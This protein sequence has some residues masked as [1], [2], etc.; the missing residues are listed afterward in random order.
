MSWLDSSGKLWLFGG[1]GYDSGWQ[2]CG[3]NDLWKYDPATREWTWVSGSSSGNQPGIYGT[4]GAADPSNVPGA[5]ICAVSWLDSRRQAL[6]LRG[7]L[8][9]LAIKACSMT[10]GSMT[11]QAMNGPG[12]PAVVL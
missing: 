1:F 12:Y 5:R 7:R 9:R 8:I 10:C 11:R 2:R 4:K 6:A 3:L